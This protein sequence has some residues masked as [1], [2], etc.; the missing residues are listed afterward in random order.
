MASVTER[1]TSFD[2]IKYVLIACVVLGHTIHL[3]FSG[4]NG[5]IFSFIYS[6]HMPAFVII[7]GYF[8]KVKGNKE[9]WRGILELLL[10]LV[11][12]QVLY[13]SNDWFDPMDFSLQ[14]ALKRAL[15]FIYP[16]RATW[17]LLSLCF[18]RIIMQY[19]PHQIIDNKR[20]M[21]PFS[22]LMAII[23][24]FVP[25]DFCLSF[26]RT[27][28]FFPF[29]LLGHYIHKQELWSK[30]RR[31]KKVISIS[32]IVFYFAII[33][34]LPNFPDSMLTGCYNYYCGLANWKIMLAL[35]VF[36]Y[37]WV[38]PLAFCVISVIP[39]TSFLQ[40]NGKDTMF[41]LLYHPF[42][43]WFVKQMVIKYSLPT[44]I[45]AILL[46]MIINMFVMYWMNKINILR[47]LTKPVSI[48]R[49]INIEK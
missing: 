11:L 5:K 36:S 9:F 40:K 12:F 37:I 33:F 7:S 49:N 44:N 14:G 38:L 29:F 10:I 27:F 28:Y 48:I 46:Y 19:T 2:S 3:D 41:Y 15:G 6:F 22:L 35:R 30:I 42:F 39:D 45:L 8:F 13:F 34:F 47:F 18:W 31:I 24:G 23:A 43:I 17:Y 20:I 16:K 32:V 1:D 25:L 26:Q 21:L 4:L